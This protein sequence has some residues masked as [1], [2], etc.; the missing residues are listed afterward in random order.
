MNCQRQTGK[1]ALGIVIGLLTIIIIGA[2]L[3]LTERKSVPTVK[4]DSSPTPAY[5][6]YNFGKNG[7]DRVID[8]GTVPISL[9]SM[10]NSACLMHDRVLLRQLA[11]EGWTLR[12][13]YFNNGAE[14]LPY[15]DRLDIMLI[16]DLPGLTAM[17]THNFGLFAN[18]RQSY[19]TIIATRM[20]TPEDFKG[21]RVGY[22]PK[23]TSHFAIDRALKTANLS[24]AEIVSVPM[25]LKEMEA[26]LKNRT[27]DAV[28]AWEP[29]STRLLNTI[30]GSTI[31]F[32]S[33]S[34]GFV[35]M[36][37]DFTARHPEVQQS[38][39]AA[40]ARISRWTRQDERNILF[41]L[42]WVKEASI[43]FTGKSSVEPDNNGLSLYR[44]EAIDNPSFPML[45]LNLSEEKGLFF[46]QFQ[47]A[48]SLGAIPS[49]T[50][51]ET[52]RSHIDT[53]TL[54][55]IIEEGH[56]WELDRFDYAP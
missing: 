14:M 18:T 36:N 30:P 20:L 2:G 35:L 49:E 38:L 12:E 34:L 28:V 8:I 42:K 21:L 50:P 51:W 5:D 29:V 15:A 4:P 45:P 13:H 1:A 16:G 25:Q 47:F 46:Q 32:R 26:A 43:A 40:F 41:G 23:T 37:L 7:A 48:K 55:A 11:A 31:V 3:W 52:V 53:K 33:A 27:V 6:S 22:P 44:K 19:N 10:F 24:L 39:L 9:N 17:A 56:K 54:P